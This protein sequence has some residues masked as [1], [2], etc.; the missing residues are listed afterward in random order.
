MR[1]DGNRTN[2]DPASAPERTESAQ[3]SAGATKAPSP[4]D[5][6]ADHVAL[7]KDAMLANEAIAAANTAHDIRPEAVT[8]AKALLL[9]GKVGNDPNTLA[10]RMIDA[11][12]SLPHHSGD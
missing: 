11:A 9:E 10:D 2:F 4:P 12:L 6:T 5:G 7:S 3:K 1:I 8:R